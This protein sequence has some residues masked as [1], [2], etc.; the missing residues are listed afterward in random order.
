MRVE[1]S[2]FVKV[3]RPLEISYIHPI[4]KTKFGLIPEVY[5]AGSARDFR[6]TVYRGIGYKVFSR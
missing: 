2:F 4:I 5:K 6:Y 1:K 3:A